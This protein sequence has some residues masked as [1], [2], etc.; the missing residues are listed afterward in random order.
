MKIALPVD[1]RP[2]VWNKSVGWGMFTPNGRRKLHGKKGYEKNAERWRSGSDTW[3]A[4]LFVGFNVGQDTVFEMADLVAI[5]RRVREDQTGDPSSTFLS[6]HGIYR[7][8]SGEVVEEPGAQVII[9]NMGATP[10]KFENDMTALA[11][12]I[13]EEMDQEE[14]VVELQ[15]GGV[16]QHVIGIGP[17]E[18]DD[19]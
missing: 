10:A 2:A 18:I 3:A 11:E 19:D 17:V 4:R 13:A 16:V 1:T 7:H 8:Q 6:Q 5:V 9:I 15:R 12:V 14:V